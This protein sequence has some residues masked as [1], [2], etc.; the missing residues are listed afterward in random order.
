MLKKK[1][2][3]RLLAKKIS[4]LWHLAAGI[5]KTASLEWIFF[6]SFR[7]WK[8]FHIFNFINQCTLHSFAEWKT[9]ACFSVF[10]FFFWNY[11]AIGLKYDHCFV[12][13]CV[14]IYIYIYMLVISQTQRTST[15]TCNRVWTEYVLRIFHSNNNCIERKQQR[16]KIHKSYTRVESQVSWTNKTINYSKEKTMKFWKKQQQQFNFF[17]FLMLMCCLM[18]PYVFCTIPI[19]WS[20]HNRCKQFIEFRMCVYVFG[21][22]FSKTIHYFV[23]AR[24]LIFPLDFGYVDCSILTVFWFCLFFWKG[25]G[26]K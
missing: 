18:P 19:V 26:E 4:N 24:K 2:R 10:L 8:Y 15:Y 7:I 22:H 3:Y 14:S 12:L 5:K 6:S 1:H 21:N 16:K 17:L 9:N 20:R 11:N 25:G 23:C 13:P